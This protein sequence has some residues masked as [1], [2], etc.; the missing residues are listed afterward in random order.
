M[1]SERDLALGFGGRVFRA[2]VFKAVLSL[3]LCILGL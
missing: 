2:L 1:L 3:P